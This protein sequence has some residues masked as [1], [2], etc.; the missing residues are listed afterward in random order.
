M[1][2]RSNNNAMIEQDPVTERLR[3]AEGFRSILPG[4]W[5][6]SPHLK[7][8]ARPCKRPEEDKEQ[9]PYDVAFRLAFG[10][11]S[12]LRHNLYQV[13]G[14]N[15]A[16]TKIEKLFQFKLTLCPQKWA[17]YNHSL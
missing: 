5:G 6:Q 7:I 8:L 17:R 12:I 9:N 16:K 2:P 15:S 1:Q 13:N 3:Q 14:L 11:R 10:I 4:V